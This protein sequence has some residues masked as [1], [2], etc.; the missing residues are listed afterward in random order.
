MSTAST[1]SN[2]A[3]KQFKLSDFEI[4]KNLGKGKFGKVKIAKHKKTGMIF[5]LKKINK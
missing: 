2:K 1:S 5:S 4:G 3:T